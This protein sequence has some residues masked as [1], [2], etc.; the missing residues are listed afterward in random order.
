MTT[1]DAIL[2][3]DRAVS[4]L[5]KAVLADRLPHGFIFGGPIGVGKGTTARALATV[6]LC[7]RPQG[8]Q[9][10]G[11]CESCRGMAASSHPDFHVIFKELIRYHDKTGK[12]KGTTL[13]IDVIRPEL[14]EKAGRKSV[15]GRG[16]VFIVEQAELMQAPAQNAMLKTLEEPAGRT[17]IVLLTDQPDS[18]LQTIR[19]RCQLVRFGL[20]P[21]DV[22]TAQLKQRGIA[23]ADARDAAVFARGS[24][25]QALQW[26]T[27]GVVPRARELVGM[28]DTLFAGRRVDDLWGWFKKSADAYA[29][30]Q[31]ERDALSSKDQATRE[32]LGLYLRLASEHLRTKLTGDN[33]TDL[34]RAADA[35][36]VI[37]RAEN[38]LDSNVNTALV[39]QQLAVALER[40]PSATA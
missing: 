15:M 25:G 24:I 38:Y 6:F 3:Q 4:T 11:Q 17:L 28:F 31:L 40:R 32:G 13:S 1:F 27:D 19:S 39:F 9:P 5:R 30:K 12:S 18:L 8:D 34:E 26:I 23:D 21:D 2:G 22:V 7:E 36:D 16:K 14:V 20:L 35:I 37:V 29:E 10:C 33:D